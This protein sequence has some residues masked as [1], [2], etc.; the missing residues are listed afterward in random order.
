M[1]NFDIFR[2]QY[3]NSPDRAWL[4]LASYRLKLTTFLIIN[5]IVIMSIWPSATVR[6]S[7]DGTAS[8]FCYVGRSFSSSNQ[9]PWLFWKCFFRIPNKVKHA[10]FINI[11]LFSGGFEHMTSENGFVRAGL[12]VVS[13]QP[14]RFLV[15]I[16]RFLQNSK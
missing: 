16:K 13:H 11:M 6:C 8:S 10:S 3:R 1:T 4:D 15:I 2:T 5:E 7:W 9:I 14:M 12:G